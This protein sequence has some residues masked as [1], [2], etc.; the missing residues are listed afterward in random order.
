MKE[1]RASTRN[2]E[3]VKKNPNLAPAH[4]CLDDCRRALAKSLLYVLLGPKPTENVTPGRR[5]AW[6]QVEHPPPPDFL[7]PVVPRHRGGCGGQR[8]R[9]VARF[10][11][12]VLLQVQRRRAATRGAAIDVPLLFSNASSP[13]FHALRTPC[14]GAYTRTASP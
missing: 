10:R 6:P 11:G 12:G 1:A 9:D 14:P 7:A 2:A 4:H 8:A 13:A 3:R 5:A